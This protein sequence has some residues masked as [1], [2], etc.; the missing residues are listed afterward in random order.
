MITTGQ[1]ECVMTYQDNNKTALITD[2]VQ[3]SNMNLMKNCH[4]T[5]FDD[6]SSSE[7]ELEQ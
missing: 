5:W 3:K 7:S 4:Q 1:V 2:P 6:N